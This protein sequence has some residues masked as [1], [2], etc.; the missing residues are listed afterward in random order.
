M[1][2][3]GFTFAKIAELTGGK[4]TGTHSAGLRFRRVSA[5]AVADAYAIVFAADEEALTSAMAS[6]AGII[7]APTTSV[8][9]GED[10]R[11]IRV[12]D[13]RFAFALC[14]RELAL[15][16]SPVEHQ[17]HG[18]AMVDPSA[19]LGLRIR[20]GAVYVMQANA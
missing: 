19:Q 7:L 17:V 5:V 1:N 2:L 20:I 9:A 15:L 8:P 11:I 3:E 18:S 6:K 10:P 14:A 16:Q 12:D 4:V 13:P